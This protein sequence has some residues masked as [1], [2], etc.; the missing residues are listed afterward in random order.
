MTVLIVKNNIDTNNNAENNNKHNNNKQASTI[1][2]SIITIVIM[3]SIDRVWLI[4][5]IGVSRE[6]SRRTWK[7]VIK[8]DCNAN[9]SR[10]RGSGNYLHKRSIAIEL[11]RCCCCSGLVFVASGNYE[12]WWM[13]TYVNK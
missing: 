3:Y 13:R 4:K 10:R 5:R 11:G 8:I 1:D 7:E 12:A 6:L 2:I 9:A